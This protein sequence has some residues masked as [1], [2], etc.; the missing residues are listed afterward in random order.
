MYNV[1]KPFGFKIY[2]ELTLPSFVGSFTCMK[3]FTMQEQNFVSQLRMY[4]LHDCK[5][6]GSIE[7]DV[8]RMTWKNNLSGLVSSDMIN[9]KN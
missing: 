8:W 2:L 9:S 5:L 3:V 4:L 1:C 7:V 6:N